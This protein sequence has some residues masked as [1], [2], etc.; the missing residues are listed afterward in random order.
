MGVFGS[1]EPLLF[2]RAQE[3]P[4]PL[5]WVWGGTRGEDRPVLALFLCLS[6]SNSYVQLLERGHGATRAFRQP[7]Y[8]WSCR[9]ETLITLCTAVRTHRTRL[10]LPRPFFCC[11]LSKYI[12]KMHVLA[13]LK[14]PTLGTCCSDRA[15]SSSGHWHKTRPKLN[16]SL[17]VPVLCEWATWEVDP[18]FW[19]L[20][21]RLKGCQHWCAY[22]SFNRKRAK[23]RTLSLPRI[24]CGEESRAGVPTA[25]GRTVLRWFTLHIICIQESV[26]F[27]NENNQKPPT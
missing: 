9:P 6:D 21:N 5:C 26:F 3:V 2:P 16:F 7:P 18:D 10:Y 11:L 1:P 22:L 13:L 17:T 23:R 12:N 4:D 15:H 25:S 24:V 8:S 20:G 14:S 27:K 19:G